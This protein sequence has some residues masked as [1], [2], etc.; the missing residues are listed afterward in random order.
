MSKMRSARQR[1][2]PRPRRAVKRRIKLEATRDKQVEEMEWR[3]QELDKKINKAKQL[4]NAMS[5]LMLDAKL[6]NLF[7]DSTTPTHGTTSTN[8]TI[9]FSPEHGS[10]HQ[11]MEQETNTTSGMPHHHDVVDEVARVPVFN[12]PLFD[13]LNVNCTATS[14]KEEESNAV[15]KATDETQLSVEEEPLEMQ[16][17]DQSKPR[18]R[19]R[20]RDSL[21]GVE[22]LNEI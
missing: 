7:G 6:Q 2:P 12:L 19:E 3:N 15:I 8:N 14:Q 5:S 22:A 20:E 21:Y 10:F 16:Q 11:Q 1:M 18:E 4:I 17:N 13:L 9:T